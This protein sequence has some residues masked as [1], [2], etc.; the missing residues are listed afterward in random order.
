MTIAIRLAGQCPPSDR[1]GD[2][3][4]A[5]HMSAPPLAITRSHPLTRYSTATF[6]T[7]PLDEQR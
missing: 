3:L 6:L 4:T 5:T 7:P 2:V 1:P